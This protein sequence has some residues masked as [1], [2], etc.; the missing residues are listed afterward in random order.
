[1]EILNIISVSLFIIVF[2][3]LFFSIAYS[4]LSRAF[5]WNK[6]ARCVVAIVCFTIVCLAAIV[7]I[8]VL[9]AS[10]ILVA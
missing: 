5:N 4:C 8:G 7:E 10:V 3:V 1:M 6:T 9:I 2:A